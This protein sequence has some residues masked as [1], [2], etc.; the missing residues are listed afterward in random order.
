MPMALLGSFILIL[1]LLCGTS[2]VPVQGDDIFSTEE[3]RQLQKKDS[4][5]GRI[6]IY[7]AASVRIQKNVQQ[8]VTKDEFN[9]VPDMLKIWTLLLARSLED[10]ETNLKAK[11]KP[12]SLIN[13]EIQVR[14]AIVSTESYKIKAP[15]DQQDAFDNCIAQAESAHKKF[16]EILFRL[17][18]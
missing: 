6:K 4:V 9:A 1:N 10:I 18:S 3:I 11:T 14:K 15:A 13:Y 17:K 16:V 5:D 7:Q 8:S 12:R 2:S